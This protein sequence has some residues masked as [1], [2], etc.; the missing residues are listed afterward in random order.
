M[1][2]A[3]WK[4]ITVVVRSVDS[5]KGLGLMRPNRNKKAI[6]KDFVRDGDKFPIQPRKSFSCKVRKFS[7]LTVGAFFGQFDIARRKV[8]QQ[9]PKRG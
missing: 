6:L 7:I 5:R 3:K 1:I 8:E 2:Q 9:L 4:Q